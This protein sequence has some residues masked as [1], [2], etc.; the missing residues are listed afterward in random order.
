MTD[1][2]AAP[3][4]ALKGISKSFGELT[5]NDD[6]SFDIPHGAILGLLGE[7]GAGKTTVMSALAG[8]YLPDRGTIRV[9]GEL[10]ETGSPRLAVAAGMG[11]VHQQFRLVDRLSGYEN[12]LLARDV[13][14]KR[15]GIRD[16]DRLKDELG[17][18]LDLRVKAWQLS[19]GQRQQLEILR[20]LA[21]G[22]RVLI[23]DEP[24]SVLSPLETKKLFA[25]LRRIA[26]GR[27]AAVL[28]SHKLREILAVATHIV[29]MRGGRVVHSGVAGAHDIEELARLV[30]GRRNLPES[31][32]TRGASSVADA[33]LEVKNLHV[34]GDAGGVAVRG[35]NF[36]VQPGE[37]VAILG[38]TG[39]GQSELMEAIGGMRSPFKGQI[40]APSRQA[41]D[42]A[43]IPSKHLGVALAPSLNLADNAILGQQQRPPLTWWLPPGKVCAKA[44]E[45]VDAFGVVGAERGPVRKLSGGNLQRLVLGREL[46]SEPGLILADYPTR[47]LDVASAAQIRKA[48]VSRADAGAAVLLSS[49]EL[50]ETLAIASRVLVMNGGRIAG[51]FPATALDMDELS[52]LMAGGQPSS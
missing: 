35:V 3:L 37:L 39:N 29:V 28:I 45:T 17:F 13:G 34:H 49:E 41:G 44:A 31:R 42:T 23:L 38:V 25:I 33:I 6:V 9:E 2:S 16:I 21:I 27:R 5:A 15:F 8:L 10:L 1:H 24:T 14:P 46:Q 52:T 7:N 18:A 51:D 50:E 22:A 4:V 32:R 30:I 47:G 40:R 43:F 12:C 48:L 26:A 20:N 19:L 36:T 11:M